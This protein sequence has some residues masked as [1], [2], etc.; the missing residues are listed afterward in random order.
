M[1]PEFESN[2]RLKTSVEGVA[3]SVLNNLI[4]EHE[5]RRVCQPCKM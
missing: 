4:R 5:A 3:T 1:D 2:E